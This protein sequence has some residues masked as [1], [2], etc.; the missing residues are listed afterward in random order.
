M[1][2]P[3]YTVTLTV[4]EMESGGV[5][6]TAVTVDNPNLEVTKQGATIAFTIA[7][8]GWTWLPDNPYGF[9]MYGNKQ[10]GSGNGWEFSNAL[11]LSNNNKTLTIVDAN[12]LD[13]TFYYICT[14]V[15][16]PNGI[17]GE[18]KAAATDPAVVNKGLN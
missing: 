18:M 12:D 7:T 15:N 9:L 2:K 8:P 6:Y 11:G 13:E 1:A 16:M 17:N 5:C 3:D 14:L 4:S 10:A